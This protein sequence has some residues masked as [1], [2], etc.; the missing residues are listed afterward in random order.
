MDTQARTNA[1]RK[2]PWL[3]PRLWLAFGV[4]GVAAAVT[5][6]QPATAQEA[7]TQDTTGLATAEELQEVVGPIALYP[8]D[9]VAI[10][11]PASTYP[12]QIVQAARFLE[13]RERDATLK[14]DEEWDDSVVALLNYP[15]VVKLLN[16]DLDW[17]YDLGTAVLNQRADVLSAIQDFR[18]EAYAAGNLRSDD[19][20]TVAREDDT[21]EIKPAD[22]QVI[23]VPYYEPERVV[24]YQPTPVYYYYPRPYP[25]YYYPYPAHHHFS[26]GFFWGVNTWF[27]IGWHSHHVHAYDPFYYGHPYYGFNYYSPYYVRNVYVNVNH[28]HY[29]DYVWQPKSPRYGGRP[30]VRGSEGRVYTADRE[31]RHGSLDPSAAATRSR[32]GSAY[33]ANGNTAARTADGAAP[34]RQPRRGVLD[35]NAAAARAREGS[36]YR[37]N[38]NATAAGTQSAARGTPL[39]R[40][41]QPQ[42]PRGQSAQPRQ[43]A[44]SAD[45]AAATSQGGYRSSGG[46]M[47]QALRNRATAQPNAATLPDP[48][49]VA[50]TN[51]GAARANPGVSPRVYERSTGMPRESSRAAAAPPPRESAPVVREQS[52]GGM[53]AQ[54]SESGGSYRGSSGG[55]DSANRGGG[56]GGGSYRGGGNSA[57]S[58]N[59]AARHER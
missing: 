1:I 54:R 41:T 44:A 33:R 5:A 26:T 14:P 53:S 10:V 42:I 20:Q 17:T 12:L 37:P 24:V 40:A 46:G 13:D 50:R 9:L 36:A 3:A 22:P 43:P 27:S 47:S 18:D 21:I 29:P 49:V 23:Y 7:T 58:P 59:S 35:S 57:R 30:V 16:D 51:P 8:D 39:G 6:L 34:D 32:E 56:N 19:R 25:V 2:A 48:G 45:A 15:E 11:L 55:G 4:L 52:G 31:P 38:E 28:Y